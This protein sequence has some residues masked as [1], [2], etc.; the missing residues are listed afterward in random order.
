MSLVGSL[1]DLGLGD[2][3]QI[4]SLSRKSGLLLLRSDHRE[5][6]IVFQDGRVI[7]ALVGGAPTSLRELLEKE[8][9]VSH[10]DLERIAGLAG[11]RGVSLDAALA[12]SG[13]LSLEQLNQTK[14]EAAEQAVVAMF[15]WT[16]G[17][18]SFDVREDRQ[19]FDAALFVPDGI[20]AQYLAMEGA[21]VRDERVHEQDLG[22][23]HDPATSF[24]DVEEELREAPRPTLDETAASEAPL[25]DAELLDEVEP[26]TAEPVEEGVL[27]ADAHEPGGPE[28]DPIETV[29][30]LEAGD[31]CVGVETESVREAVDPDP[32]AAAHPE[33]PVVAIDPNLA[34]LEWL[35]GALAGEFGKVHIFQRSE[36]GIAR[37]RQYLARGE[38]PLL[39]LS[40]DAPSDPISGSTD[41]ADMVRRLKAQVARMPILMLAEAG[42]SPQVPGAD[43][44]VT[45]PHPR[46]LTTRASSLEVANYAQVLV[47]ALRSWAQGEPPAPP[48]R[49]SVVPVPG[50]PA[51]LPLARLKEISARLRDPESQGE[52]L[53]LVMRFAAQSFS[54]VAMFLIRDDMAVG[55]AQLG[56][57]RAGGPDDR[58]LREIRL[59]AQDPAW[60]R[61]VFARGGAVCGPPTDA[62]DRLLAEQLGSQ[63][64]EQA[65]VAP[66]ESGERIVA[67]LYADNLP[68][69]TPIQD[70]LALEVVLH[71]AGLALDR[72]ALERQLAEAEAAPLVE[73]QP[74]DPATTS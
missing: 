58:A 63:L 2:I 6:R 38:L 62:G 31:P 56:L 32:V 66:L 68:E 12:E 52:V 72:A 39:I 47:T 26:D 17:D 53:P 33:L 24:A 51:E 19:E 64:P 29:S 50:G 27:V 44:V 46:E 61:S 41:L 16:A 71:E 36:L 42:R 60:F 14:R 49:E 21:R 59:S 43:A 1:E 45:K 67:M 37:I 74:H 57:S 54:R 4:V 23:A 28:A 18:F 8:P 73:A 15:A 10:A 55:M 3:L 70:T 30:P 11:E 65:Y 22:A 69:R 5:G 34:I 48:S 35:K 7:G 13:C 20:D 40:A 25:V 9:A